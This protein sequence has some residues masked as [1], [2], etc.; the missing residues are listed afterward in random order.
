[1]AAQMNLESQL[2]QIKGDQRACSTTDV[3]FPGHLVL[4]S[5]PRT[6][7]MAPDSNPRT[8]T[9]RFATFEVDLTAGE[10]RKGGMKIKVH[11]QPFEVLAMLLERPG[12]IVPREEFK[13]KLWPTDTFVDFDHGV[14]PAINRLREA[15]GAAAESL[16]SVPR[17]QTKKTVP[18]AIA[19]GIAAAAILGLVAMRQRLFARRS[20]P[21]IE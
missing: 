10:L 18:L 7:V 11:G 9:V 21:A 1:M 13:Q 20:G 14:N 4:D 2:L 12:E 8:R 17:K 3:R 19:L 16:R 6:C 5:R 15:V